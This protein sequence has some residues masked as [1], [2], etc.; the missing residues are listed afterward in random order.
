MIQWF[1]DV[2]TDSI[3]FKAFM[4]VM[5]LSFGVWG[6]G[7]VIAP[8]IDPNVAIQGGRFEVRASEVQRRFQVQIERLRENLGAEAAADPALKQLV[9]NNT[10]EELRQTA[11][12]N[13]AALEM[14]IDVTDARV[15]DNVTAQAAFKDETGKFNPM[16]FAEVLAQNQMTEP[17]FAKLVEDDLRQQTLMGPIGGSAAAPKALV[18]PLFAYRAETRIAD[19]LLVPAEA[20]KTPAVPTEEQIK[21]T[22]EDNIATFTAPE[23]R[24]VGAVVLARAELV[25]LSSIDDAAVHAFYDENTASY[26]MP[27]TR[28]ISQ[29]LFETKEAALAARALMA[30]GDDLA[31][32]AA[33]A[34]IDPP[35]EL[36]ERAMN[37]PIVLPLGEAAK[38]PAGEVSQPVQTDL[39]WHLVQT[40]AIV[41]E[42]TTPFAQVE[43]EIRIKLAEEKGADALYDAAEKLEDEIAAGTPLDEA[44]KVAGG[45]FVG[46]EAIDRSGSRPDGTPAYDPA[47][48]GGVPPESFLSLAFSTPAGSESKLMDFAGGYYIL[49]VESVT[50]PT[51]K[52]LETVRAEVV[53]LW[54]AQERVRA[55]KAEAEKIAKELTPS[56]TMSSLVDKDKRLSYARLG[57]LTRF[58][59]SLA[60]DYVVDSKRVGPEMLDQLFK[61]KVGDVIVAPVAG[62]YIVARLREIVPPKP[63]GDLAR[64][65]AD[66]SQSTRNALA[67]DL[68]QQ[69]SA[70]LAERYPVTL[71]AKAIAEIGGVAAPQ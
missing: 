71:N 59:E 47:Q 48:I 5:V 69:F 20:M 14:G 3:L 33:K 65:F 43:N 67:Q 39:G 32:I 53:K 10:V 68:M 15:R 7:D 45:R 11:V 22:Y 25:P 36:G 4:V 66:V 28:K 54:Q 63:E 50:P 35:V 34:K 46:F 23:Y 41:P 19:T 26:V 49:K 12:T 6:I 21:Q 13:M 37:D 18:E 31:K 38:L 56:V 17:A 40:T 58:G 8:S 1:K 44:A 16:R 64:T 9:L 30:P 57:P 24:K 55:A 27:E 29:L 2:T 60:R 51:P 70:A 42:R 62:G 61:A 52:P